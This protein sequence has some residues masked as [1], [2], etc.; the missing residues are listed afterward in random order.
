MEGR[1]GEEGEG[2]GGGGGGGGLF[3]V[4]WMVMSAVEREV[5]R[6]IWVQWHPWTVQCAAPWAAAWPSRILLSFSTSVICVRDQG[7]L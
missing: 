6:R 1:R 2:G 3:G 4:T 7:P 5:G